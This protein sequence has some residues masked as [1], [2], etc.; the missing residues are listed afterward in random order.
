MSS[1]NALSCAPAARAWIENSC[2]PRILHIFD[3]VCNL[4]DERGE[5]LS[6]V[7]PGIGNGPFNLV[8]EGEICFSEH[9]SLQSL[10]TNSPGHLYLGNLNINTADAK[11]W[12][13]R[14]DWGRLHA[15]RDDI[16]NQLLSLS[17]PNY[18][19]L[20]PD[21]LVSNLTSS[22][23]KADIS[24]AK[25]VVSQLAGLGQ[26]LTPSGDDFI[27]GAI[28]ATLILHP[29]EVA[30]LLAE[31]ITDV[32]APLTTS[33]SA[34]WLRAVGRGEAGALWHE[35]FDALT[36]AN[37]VAI[38]GARKRLLA[39]GHTSGIDALTGF[40]GTFISHAKR[41]TKLCPS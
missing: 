41:E 14:P 39:V 38:Q 1:T 6:I 8:I 21:S 40:T 29:P 34:A 23:W 24:S 22:L 31:E 3:Y 19:E 18:R 27:M 26:G 5:L 32:A 4:I 16:L 12:N 13:P 9:L 11:H 28:Y 35:F 20:I 2:H 36:S 37:V 10:I 33:L 7:T 15:R 30:D 25:A 17:V